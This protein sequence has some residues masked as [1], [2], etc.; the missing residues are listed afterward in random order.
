LAAETLDYL[1]STIYNAVISGAEDCKYDVKA[2]IAA[3]TYSIHGLTVN[4]APA[5]AIQGS[6]LPVVI[7]SSTPVGPVAAYESP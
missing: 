1:T 5:D 6:N 3:L 7:V 2:N 4:V